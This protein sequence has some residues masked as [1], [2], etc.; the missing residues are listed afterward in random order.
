MVILQAHVEKCV[1]N[2]DISNSCVHW[3]EPDSCG[4]EVG[5]H[6]FGDTLYFS[7]A[8]GVLVSNIELSNGR[9]NKQN[10]PM[11]DTVV[12]TVTALISS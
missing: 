4:I 1:V 11:T 5:C 10:E 12:N 6:F 9:N 8:I 3:V 2:N 7:R